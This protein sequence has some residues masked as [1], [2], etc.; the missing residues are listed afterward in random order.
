MSASAYQPPRTPLPEAG[1][2]VLSVHLSSG[3]G[4]WETRLIWPEH[5]LVQDESHH[6]QGAGKTIHLLHG[7]SERPL[8]QDKVKLS[9]M[10]L[11]S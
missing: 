4:L 10:S 11:N 7:E 2:P 8:Q 3:I 6:L 1:R 5:G 9:E